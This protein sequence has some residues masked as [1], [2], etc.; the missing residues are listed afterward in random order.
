MLTD[1]DAPPAESCGCGPEDVCPGCRRVG[2]D[3]QGP[4]GRPMLTDADALLAG[5]V[6]YP[7]QWD[8]LLVLADVLDGRGDPVEALGWRLLAGARRWPFP[9]GQGPY[10][11]FWWANAGGKEPPAGVGSW[12]DWVLPGEAFL[13]LGGRT[14]GMF[15]D[16][17]D[18]PA[19]LAD[20]ARAFGLAR[21]AGWR[22]G[23]EVRRG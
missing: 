19:A 16:Y 14:D 21:L 8:R 18:A 12:G 22:P 13:A 17:D 3:D 23:G 11:A 10:G 1:A 6:E 20:A 2:P 4:R 5:I 9:A 7:R 15:A